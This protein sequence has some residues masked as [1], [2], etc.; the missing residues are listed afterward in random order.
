MTS[1]A[2]HEEVA[3]IGSSNECVICRSPITNGDILDMLV[4]GHLFHKDCI[5]QW[6]SP[7][8]GCPLCKRLQLP[9][10]V[11]SIHHQRRFRERRLSIDR[12]LFLFSEKLS[13]RQLEDFME[14]SLYGNLEIVCQIIGVKVYGVNEFGLKF[15]CGE[16]KGFQ[17]VENDFDIELNIRKTGLFFRKLKYYFSDL[18]LFLNNQ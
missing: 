11:V 16:V 5:I 17:E 18:H 15:L 9:E 7:V 10:A 14:K 12:F 2:Q 3:V 1:E 6:L 4:C 8:K 13:V